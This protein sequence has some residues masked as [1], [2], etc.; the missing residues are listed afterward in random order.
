[1]QK[2]QSPLADRMRPETLEDFLGQDEI[3]GNRLFMT[4]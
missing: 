1:M 4:E 2:D 3:L